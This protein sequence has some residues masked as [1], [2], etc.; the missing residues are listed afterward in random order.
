MA[1]A[2]DVRHGVLLPL[3]QSA[4][5]ESSPPK[6]AVLPMPLSAQ[7]YRSNVC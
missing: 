6:S 3:V 5:N 7:S 1:A 4:A 2:T